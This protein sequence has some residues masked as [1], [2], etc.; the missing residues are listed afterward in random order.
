[1]ELALG[2]LYH[3]NTLAGG[4]KPVSAL[5]STLLPPSCAYQVSNT[6]MY[7]VTVVPKESPV[8][9]HGTGHFC[10]LPFPFFS[11]TDLSLHP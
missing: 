8:G 2:A 9:G 1:M 6:S 11:C 4:M 7:S 3:T 10:S 5:G